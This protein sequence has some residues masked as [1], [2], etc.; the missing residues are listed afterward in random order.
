MMC[1]DWQNLA[2]LKR[3]LEINPPIVGN[4]PSRMSVSF[5]SEF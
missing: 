4:T 1:V 2:F 3:I 5:G